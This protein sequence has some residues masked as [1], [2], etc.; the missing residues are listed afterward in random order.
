MTYSLIIWA[1]LA[2]AQPQVAFVNQMVDLETCQANRLAVMGKK[3]QGL[4]LVAVCVK[5]KTQ[6]DP[7]HQHGDTP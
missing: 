4:G 1:F 3:N 2:G 5:I 6:A 7:P